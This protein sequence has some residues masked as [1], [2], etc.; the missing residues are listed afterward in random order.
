MTDFTPV[1]EG[2]RAAAFAAVL[3]VAAS[4]PPAAAELVVFADG[5]FMT[6]AGFELLGDERMRLDLDSGGAL[7]VPLSRVARIVDDGRSQEEVPEDP[8][9]FE[10]RFSPEQPVPDVP[11]GE[12][13]HSAA[14]KH[15]LNPAL[16]AA[17]ARAESAFRKDVVSHKGARGLMQL[18]PATARRF[19]I[20]PDQAFEPGPA[21]EAGGRYLRWLAD[22]FED[23]L[24]RVLAAYNAGEG[25]VDRYGGVPPYRETR[26]Y[27]QRIYR[28][29]GLPTESLTPM[30]SSGR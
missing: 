15:G 25:A 5:G 16:V 11:Y 4:A 3:A 17:V 12:L 9:H 23:D 27:L 13:I 1:A 30:P 28:H 2:L 26:G 7:V 10:L 8:H 24:P 29:L 19:G 14:E 22:R 18:M 20:D 6:V 21:L